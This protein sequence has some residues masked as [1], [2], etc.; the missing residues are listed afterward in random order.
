MPRR[1]GL[2]SVG[3]GTRDAGVSHC[4]MH[5]HSACANT[6][7]DGAFGFEFLDERINVDEKVGCE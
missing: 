1:F 2:E 7:L 4:C 3:S 5:T 6:N